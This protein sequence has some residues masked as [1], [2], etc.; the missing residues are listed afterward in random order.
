MP[1]KV[2]ITDH[3]TDTGRKVFLAEVKVAT[4]LLRNLPRLMIEVPDQGNVEANIQEARR[5]FS[6]LLGRLRKHFR[7]RSD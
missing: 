5:S 3:W 7:V 4:D 1:T 6:D 2:E